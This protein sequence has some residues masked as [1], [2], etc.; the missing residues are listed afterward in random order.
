MFI[1]QKLNKGFTLIELLV[2][3]AIIGVL[4][5][6]VLVNLSGAQNKAKTAKSLQY[7]QSIHNALGAYSVGVW[8]FDEGSGTV[9]KD[10]SGYNRNGTLVSNPTWRCSSNDSFYTP[11]GQGCS[12]EFNGNQTQYVRSSSLVTVPENGTI[13]GWIKG[14]NN[15][16]KN[17][18]IYPFGLNYVSLLGPSGGINDT[19][20]GIITGTSGSYDHLNWGAQNLYNGEW[21]HYLVTWIK[22]GENNYNFYLYINGK[23]IGNHRTSTRH[24]A[25]DQREIRAGVAWGTYGAHTGFIDDVRIYKEAL[26]ASEIKSLYYAGL[27]NLLVKGLI[28]E[29][30]YKERL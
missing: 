14:L 5:S 7:S 28:T 12:L 22:T 2:V 17:Q 20:S 19:R 6:I 11:S 30:E 10:S 25:G 4:A 23:Q 27:N 26:Q 21:H 8:N 16:Q 15:L 1:K 13:G 9:A 29:E 24:P 3:I 18:N